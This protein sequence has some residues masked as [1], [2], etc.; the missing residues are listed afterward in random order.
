MENYCQVAH[1]TGS[2]RRIAEHS[3]CWIY[4]GWLYILR[5]ISGVKDTFAA[6]DNARKSIYNKEEI[7]WEVEKITIA[8]QIKTAAIHANVTITELANQFGS[9]QSS[10]SQRMKTGKFTREELEKIAM[11]LGGEYISFFQFPDGKKY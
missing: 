10:F 7:E 4:R 3:G 9:S 5:E 11:I 2:N 1:K 6:V 8:E